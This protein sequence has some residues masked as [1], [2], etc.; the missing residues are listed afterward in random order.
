METEDPIVYIVDDDEAI[1]KSLARLLLSAGFDVVSYSDAH[2]FLDNASNTAT[3][4]LIL[5]I[6]LP[7]VSGLELQS[8]LAQNGFSLPIVFITGHGDI[9]M[10]V[11]AMKAGAIDFLTKPFDDVE[12][13]N[14][15]E[16]AIQHHARIQQEEA[17]MIELRAR[18]DL[19]T[20]RE[21]E[22]FSH[23]VTGRLNKQIAFDLD[24]A[25]KTIKVHRARVMEKMEARTFADLV[26][27]GEQL[28]PLS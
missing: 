3:G 27:M 21:K 22:V 23:V 4:C 9:P 20:R 24:V 7:G 6:R 25:E 10:S 2:Q 19:L 28:K 17:E 8:L 14:A 15:V 18:Y 11:S 16:V 13:I 12:L 5:D 26:R 1:R